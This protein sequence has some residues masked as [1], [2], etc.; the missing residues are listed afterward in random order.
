MAQNKI[1]HNQIQAKIDRLQRERKQVLKH[2][3]LLDDKITTLTQSL[4]IMQEVQKADE[5]NTALFRYPTYQR[6]FKGKLR[7]HLITIMK[8]QP[9]RYFTVNELT[10][11]AL[12][13]DKQEI[14]ITDGHR[15]SVRGALKYLLNKGIVERYAL[16]AIDVK[17]KFV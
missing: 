6:L 2:L 12:E 17:W 7:K 16:N 11:L 4:T 1:Y 5:F 9:K 3:A 13:Q 15:T 14:N 8:T 10:Q